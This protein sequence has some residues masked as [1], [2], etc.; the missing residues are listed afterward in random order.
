MVLLIVDDN[1]AVRR[2]IGKVVA[3]LVDDVHEC[4]DGSEALDAYRRF[5]PDLVLMDVEMEGMDGITATR[6]I[7]S[8]FPDARIVVV[9]VYGDAQMRAAAR[10]A[11]ACDYV[12]KDNLLDLRRLVRAPP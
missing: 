3:D 11:G 2:L 5:Q 8:E 10:A 12:L 6:R 7:R 1:A 9:T 4:S